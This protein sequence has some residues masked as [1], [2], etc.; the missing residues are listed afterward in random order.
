MHGSSILAFRVDRCASSP[1]FIT[2]PG[3]DTVDYKT[4]TLNALAAS[5]PVVV[6][7]GNRASDITA[8]MNAGVVPS[9]IF[10]KLPSTRMRS[11]R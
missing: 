10:V 1:S 9:A 2:L 6:G 8:Y 3:A 5:V 4:T 11:A 7:I